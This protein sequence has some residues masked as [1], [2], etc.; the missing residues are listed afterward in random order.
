VRATG[1]PFDPGSDP[2]RRVVLRGGAPEPDTHVSAE[3]LRAKVTPCISQVVTRVITVRT[4][5]S[6]LG[7]DCVSVLIQAEH[8][9]QVSRAG[10]RGGNK[11]GGPT[12]AALAE[13]DMRA[14]LSS[15]R[16]SMRG[17]GDCRA[18]RPDRPCTRA[19]RRARRT[20]RGSG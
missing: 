20:S 15:A 13:I 16:T 8:H 18:K 19:L 5:L 6:W 2:R 7:L 4:F 14:C 17:H 10:F 11:K 12:W 1:P 9:L 3:K